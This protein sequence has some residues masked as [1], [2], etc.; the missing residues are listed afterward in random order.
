MNYF[1]MAGFRN[2]L[3]GKRGKE[4]TYMELGWVRPCVLMEIHQ[5]PGNSMCLF[6]TTDE[7]AGLSC[8]ANLGGKLANHGSEPLW[9]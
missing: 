9:T 5:Q 1:D 2:D 3:T 8:T 6:H 7:E 4:K